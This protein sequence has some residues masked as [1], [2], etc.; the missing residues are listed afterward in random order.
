M[1]IREKLMELE[2]YNLEASDG[3]FGCRFRKLTPKELEQIMS[4]HVAEYYD[5]FRM[6]LPWWERLTDGYKN[7]AIIMAHYFGIDEIFKKK[8]LLLNL[9]DQDKDALLDKVGGFMP[10]DYVDEIVRQIG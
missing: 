2:K 10:K 3:F 6:A 1:Q 7:A 8:D 5:T 9:R 4:R